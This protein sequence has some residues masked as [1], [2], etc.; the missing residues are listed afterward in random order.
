L[1]PHSLSLSDYDVDGV[2]LKANK[3]LLLLLR[4]GFVA[5]AYP[6]APQTTILLGWC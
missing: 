2:V 5:A 4:F 3:L 6:P 1:F